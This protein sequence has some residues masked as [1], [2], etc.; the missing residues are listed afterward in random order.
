MLYHWDRK[1]LYY[2]FF[3]VV[4]FGKTIIKRTHINKYHL[5]IFLPM[6][7]VNKH[8]LYLFFVL[9]FRQKII[10]NKPWWIS[11][12]GSFFIIVVVCKK[13]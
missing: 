1:D 8:Y 9:N 2:F 11:L 13:S 3:Y 4:N 7:R 5:T 6:K 12:N 10:K